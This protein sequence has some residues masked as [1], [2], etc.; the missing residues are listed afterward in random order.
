MK[1]EYLGPAVVVFGVLVAVYGL[2]AAR[3]ITGFGDSDELIAAGY[4]LA[5]P[6]PPGYP[7][8]ISMVFGVT[9][10][11]GLNPAWWAALLAGIIGAAG[12]AV[13]TVV[14]VQVM[15]DRSWVKVV[16][17]GLIMGTSGLIWRHATHLE[18]FGLMGLFS[19]ISLW[20]VV[21]LRK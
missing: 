17:L 1:R 5:L 2:T 10:L 4:N 14:Y 15:G 18:V 3:T 8:L 16:T 11:P 12:V 13:A 9:R 7:L 6:H 19:I 20:W 21:V